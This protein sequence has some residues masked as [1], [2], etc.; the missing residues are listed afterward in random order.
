M[1]RAFDDEEKGWALEALE[2][3]IRIPSVSAQGAGIMEAARYLQGFFQQIG[4]D[5]RVMETGGNPVVFAERDVGA[6]KTILFYNHYDVQ[7]PEPLELW[8]S[9]PF[10]PTIREGRIYGRGAYDNKG[11]IIARALAM[12]ALD[13]PPVNVRFLVE[14]EE[15]VGSKNLPRFVEEHGG[16]LKADL[17]IWE[18]GSRDEEGRLQ[19]DLGCKGILALELRARGPK[20]D[21]HSSLSPIVP[22]PA[23][24]LAWALSSMK[25]RGE[26][27]EVEGFYDGVLEPT[28][29]ELEYLA[30]IP[31]DEKWKLERYGLEEFLGGAR[32]AEVLRRL[33][34]S[35]AMNISGLG[36]GYQGEGSKTVL[37]SVAMAK[38]DVRLVPE[39]RPER[40]LGAIERHLQRGGFGDIELRC[41]EGYPAGRTPM[42]DPYVGLV[43][44]A[45][46]EVYGGAVI[47]PT[48]AGSGPMY[49]FTKRMPCISA[50][51]GHADSNAHAPDESIY[52]ENL[53]LGARHMALVMERLG[54]ATSPS[55]RTP[56][57]L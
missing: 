26:E 52:V 46:R 18:S 54:E 17:C 33:Y 5:A 23:W 8:S 51:V 20:A 34:Y 28:E 37:P 56:P 14:G 50:G 39:Q 4:L 29:E 43:A 7:P 12:K 21:L 3:L 49:L 40:V 6:G 24:R 30:R 41:T 35:P 13:E 19:I 47:H 1:A 27:I 57:G 9:P 22:N 45:A 10:E 38:L 32:G 55:G 42:D 25:G 16:L 53:F 44:E 48:S 31:F 2:G 11:N 15:E 36:A